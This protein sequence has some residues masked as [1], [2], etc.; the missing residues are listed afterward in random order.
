MGDAKNTKAI[1]VNLILYQ[2]IQSELAE[3]WL[4]PAT[5][6]KRCQCGLCPRITRKEKAYTSNS[7]WN[8]LHREV[9]SFRHHNAT[10]DETV[11]LSFKFTFLLDSQNSQMEA[12]WS[13][14]TMAIT[15]KTTLYQNQEAHNT[16]LHCWETLKPCNS[17]LLTYCTNNLFFMTPKSS[18][19][20]SNVLLA[21]GKKYVTTNFKIWCGVKIGFLR[22][23]WQLQ[24]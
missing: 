18:T 14:E 19:T 10:K 12:W 3:R 13:S 7:D 5:P 23:L 22:L 21:H 11:F 17:F 2:T 1:I 8:T 16:H 6:H 4:Q 9:C 20:Y 24:D 15:Y